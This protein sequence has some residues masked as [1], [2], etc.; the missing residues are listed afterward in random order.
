MKALENEVEVIIDD[1]DATVAEM[2]ERDIQLAEMI[3]EEDGLQTQVE[4]LEGELKAI[5]DDQDET[6]K[7]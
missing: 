6:A 3:A 1:Q 4:R 7:E 5:K 2:A